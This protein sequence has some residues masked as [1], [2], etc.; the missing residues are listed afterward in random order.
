MRMS[1][2]QGIRWREIETVDIPAIVDVLQE[3]FPKRPRR[4]WAAGFERLAGNSAPFGLPRF[5]Y[6]LESAGRAV[7]TLLLIASEREDGSVC[8]NLSSWYVKPQFNLYSSL[9]VLR[10]TRHPDVTYVNV[11]PAPGT[12]RTI[13]AQGFRPFS[14]GVFAA[15]ILAGYR[16]NG[17]RALWVRPDRD[18][19]AAIPKSELRMMLDHHR[20]GCMSLWCE[21]SYVFRGRLVSPL[22]LPCAQL[23]YCPSLE[24]LARHADRIGRAL[25]LRGLM[26]MLIACNE[27]VRGL[28]GRFFPGKLP[29][30]YKG[31]AAP[32]IGDLTYTEAA[33]FG[34]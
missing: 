4:F 28:T 26:F 8:C 1:S 25:A 14:V 18:E 5:G 31:G 15:P 27:R 29:M 19:L 6:M 11:S 20:F 32:R 3:G 21:G 16:A 10:A 34:L 22:K 13:E 9:L 7:G 23:I 12:W 30:Y 17:G 33:I 24:E 2:H